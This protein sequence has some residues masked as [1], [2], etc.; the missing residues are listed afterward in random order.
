M[1]G[2]PDLDVRVR[3]LLES[4]SDYAVFVLDV[5]G[6]VASWNPGAERINGYLAEEIVGRPFSVFYTPEDIDSGRPARELATAREVGRVVDEGVRVRK[7]GSR[8]WANDVLTALHDQDGALIGFGKVTRDESA[9]RAAHEAVRAS[10]E[11]LRLMIEAVRDYAIFMLD[12]S[13]HVTSWNSGAQHLKGYTADEVIGSHFELFYSEEDRAR[14]HPQ[15]ELAIAARVG[16]YEEEGWRIRKDGSR[17]WANVLITALRE[18]SGTLVGYAKVTRDLTERRAAEQAL[19]AA[20]EDLE[21]RVRERTA[22][23]AAANREIEAFS[24]SVSHDL[25]APLR[26]LDGFSRLVLERG[27]ELDPELR[28]YLQRIRAASERMSE[29]IDAML[30]LARLT[31]AQLVRE[32]VDVTALVSAIADELRSAEP[33]R[34]VELAVARGLSVDADPRLVRIVFENLLRNAWKFTRRNEVAHVEV[35]M[36]DGELFVRDDGV[37]YPA[38]RAD[39]LFV[40]FQRL[41]RVKD[42]EGTGIGLATVQRIVLRHGGRIRSRGEIGRGAAFFFTLGP[43]ERAHEA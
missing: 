5:D 10:E 24:Y 28:D 19:R 41:H 25:R 40:P 18:P 36:A 27:R 43:P 29:L 39:K 4:L 9:R 30:G 11:R 37:G 12:P 14:K 20:N 38:E 22:E 7:D 35:G 31:R 8:F 2:A 1:T 32:R 34:R 42:F 6:R 23:F 13:G 17:F 33:S 15:E 26:S 3:A 16:R 21:R